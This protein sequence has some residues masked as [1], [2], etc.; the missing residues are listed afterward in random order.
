[1]G[2]YL[3][4]PKTRTAIDLKMA[5]FI[6]KANDREESRRR[7]QCIGAHIGPP[8][9]KPS[10]PLSEWLSEME[11]RPTTSGTQANDTSSK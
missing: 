4:P 5:K 8:G 6:D 10:R 1:M 3:L 7:K 2:V 11:Q 9:C